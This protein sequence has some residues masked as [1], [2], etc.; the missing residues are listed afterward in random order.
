MEYDY[1]SLGE[2]GEPLNAALICGW[3]VVEGPSWWTPG[4]C[5]AVLGRWSW[6]QIFGVHTAA[7]GCTPSSHGFDHE[8]GCRLPR[9]LAYD[10]PPPVAPPPL[11]PLPG[12]QSVLT[13]RTGLSVHKRAVVDRYTPLSPGAL[14]ETGPAHSIITCFA[15]AFCDTTQ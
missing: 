9:G 6:G 2:R 3:Y 8:A 4:C 5:F 13:H 10:V 1:E 11:L 15:R 7:V 14:T 12:L